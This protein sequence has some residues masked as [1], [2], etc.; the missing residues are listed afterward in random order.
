MLVVKYTLQ[1]GGVPVEFSAG[2]FEGRPAA[3]VFA[4]G[5]SWMAAHS[6]MLLIKCAIE[7]ITTTGSACS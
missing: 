7:S 4:A 1:H 3:E 2:P 5:L 6:H